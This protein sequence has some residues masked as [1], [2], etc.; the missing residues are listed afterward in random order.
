MNSEFNNQNMNQFQNNGINNGY[1][2][3]YNDLNNKNDS[4][5]NVLI[6]ILIIISLFLTALTIYVVVDKKDNSEDGNKDN[7]IQENE[8]NNDN[9]QNNEFDVEKAANDFF[10]SFKKKETLNFNFVDDVGTVINDSNAISVLKESVEII[11]I[12]DTIKNEPRINH[13]IVYELNNIYNITEKDKISG[14]IFF[15]LRDE[16]LIDPVDNAL[17]AEKVKQKYYEL[18]GQN[19]NFT[20]SADE[21]SGNSSTEKDSVYMG[22]GNACEYIEKTN[23]FDCWPAYGGIAPEHTGLLTYIYNYKKDA[24]YY[25]VYV[26]VGRYISYSNFDDFSRQVISSEVNDLKIYKDSDKD[27]ELYK[28]KIDGTNYNDFD[29]YRYTFKLNDDGKTFRFVSLDK[30]R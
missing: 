24:E 30:V 7:N 8:T 18:Y 13:K 23:M 20:T 6:V 9:N 5:K 15:Y 22:S 29:K 4:W 25:Y 10:N 28:F 3:N 1:S 2:N 17:S 27:G 19:V 12:I 21:N 26:S 16:L 14:I 11:E